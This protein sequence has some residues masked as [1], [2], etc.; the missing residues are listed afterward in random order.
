LL[1]KLGSPTSPFPP[2]PKQKIPLL[3][4]LVVPFA[5]QLLTA[6]GLAGYLS[7]RSQQQIVESLASQVGAEVGNRTEQSLTRNLQAP[8]DTTRS[9]AALLRLGLL[10]SQERVSLKRVFEE[11]LK[12]FDSVNTMAIVDERKTLLAVEKRSDGAIA[13]RVQEQVSDDVLNRYL[14]DNLTGS[15]KPLTDGNVD[16]RERLVTNSWYLAA[17][18]TGK[19]LWHLAEKLTASGQPVLTAVNVQPLYDRANSFQGVL[20]SS[21]SLSDLSHQLQGLKI[22]RTG[23]AF[24]VDQQ[25]LLIASSNGDRPFRQHA[26]RQERPEALS[27]SSRLVGSTQAPPL[28]YRRLGAVECYD[29]LTQQAA[30]S[31]VERFEGFDRV[32]DRRQFS[33]EVDHQRYFVH[34]EPLGRDQ[35]LGWLAVVVVPEADF[36]EVLDGNRRLT[37]LL[38]AGALTVAIIVGWLTASWIARPILRLSRASR[39]VALGEW[40]YP[41]DAESQVAELEVLAHSFNQ[42]AVHLQESFDRVKTA[43]QES[44]VKFT[45][46]F[47]ASPDAITIT[48]FPERRYLDVN[49]RFVEFSG[50]TREEAIGQSALSLNLV[51]NP[52]QVAR[53]ESLLQTQNCVRDVEID[54]C[55]KPGQLRTV[56]VS[57]EVIELEGQTCLLCI[58]RDITLRKQLELALQRSETKL[59]D[60][61]NSAIAS[62]TSIHVFPDGTWHYD[63]WSKGCETVFGFTPAEF[64]AD[65][66]LWLSRVL[67][68]DLDRVLV[69]NPKRLQEQQ[70]FVTQYRFRHKDGSL[71]WVSAYITSRWDA[72]LKR[73]VATA[74]DVDVSVAMRLEA[75]RKQAEVALRHSEAMLRE[76]QRVA[77][78]GSWD[79]DAIAQT[80]HWSEELFQIH[81]LNPKQPSLSAV[82]ALQFIHPDDRTALMELISQAVAAGRAYERDLRLVRPDGSMRSVEVR[83]MP[84]FDEQGI[85]V[86]MVGTTLDITERKQAEE[87]LRQSE[88]R[89]RSAFDTTAV[90]MCLTAP[91]GRFLQVN[92]S[93]CQMLGYSAAALLTLTIV[94]LT[95]PD[96][97]GVTVE[98][99][100]KLLAGEI[101][102]YHLEKRYR[103]K[104][105][106]T[107]WCLLSVSL[108]RDRAQQPLY[109]VAQIQDMTERQ[110]ALQERQH[111]NATMQA[112]NVALK[113]RVAELSTLN[114]ITQTVAAAIDL[115][116]ALAAVAALIAGRFNALETGISLLNQQQTA[117]Q[118]IAHY[119]VDPQ[120]PSLVGTVFP[121]QEDY[122]ASNLFEDRQSIVLSVTDDIPGTAFTRQRMQARK[123][124]CLMSVGLWLQGEAIGTITIATDQRGRVFTPDEVKLAET[125]AGQIA[126]AVQNA[127]LFEALQ[128]AK[129]TAEA[130]SLAKSH[131]L[132]DMGYELQTPFN[133]IF[134]RVQRLQ[135]AQTQA[136]HDSLKT[137]NH[138]SEYLLQLIHS[139]SLLANVETAPKR[140]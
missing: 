1:K 83:G 61:L 111:A 26:L 35:N 30:L 48:T 53:F 5:L 22:A 130:A 24:I 64:M 47:R 4:L 21:V 16:R 6:V 55:N 9:N 56:L 126:G 32:Q 75:E 46:V 138:D 84:L 82:E 36:I 71:R 136:Q 17:K 27:A 54:Y 69:V 103:H 44:E 99:A 67:P 123:I 81:G 63:Y 100:Q 121:L 127:R 86:R 109:F 80:T 97:L 60:V 85:Y 38:C 140:D 19:P 58:Y 8:A 129:D 18:S 76:A 66:T 37:L 57:S 51:V 2:S 73:W 102:Y 93:L 52:E 49:D 50:Y 89:F 90:S 41:V 74:V 68:E 28:T 62:I 105:G 114:H 79:Y 88:Q 125:I 128:L 7:Y 42:M 101:S 29:F 20:A 43:L 96:D 39:E 77:H 120:A 3:A 119:H 40:H 137:I 15:T 94:Q 122:M 33:F 134:E 10:N 14:S 70:T 13:A 59:N 65:Q 34:I 91:E 106:H 11:Q 23:Q 72:T 113:Q 92:A 133:N 116:A 107:I 31:I 104:D 45:K 98:H 131:F 87:A 95:H 78:I 115:P 25:G 12:L 118:M 135:Q 124:E 112:A 110:L 132:A 139:M 108:V 117:L